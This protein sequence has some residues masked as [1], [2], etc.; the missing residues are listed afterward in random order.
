MRAVRLRTEHM[1][2]PMGIDIRRPCLSWNCEGGIAQTAY[3]IS[4]RE[5]GREIWNSGRG[6]SSR[7]NACFGAELRGRQQVFWRVRLWDEENQPGEWSEEAVFEMGLLEKESFLAKWI[8]PELETAPDKRQPASWLRKRF[9]AEAGKKSRLYITCHG[10]YEAYLNGSRIGDFVLAPGTGSYDKKLA[11]Q[12]YDVTGL[13][14]S[15]ENEL[16]VILGDGWHRG[17]TGVDGDRNLFGSDVS[18]FCQLETDGKAV[19]VSEETWQASQQGPIR[20]NDMQQGECYDARMETEAAEGWHEVKTEDFGISQ[21]VCSNSVPIREWES[22]PGRILTTPNGDRVIDFG[23]NLAG[24]VEFTLTAHAGERIVLYHGEAL[25]ENGNFTNANFQ[26]GKRH[27]EGGIRQRTEYICKEGPNQYK[28][29]FCIFGFR[30]ARIETDNSLEDARFTAHAVYSEMEEAGEFTCP[31]EAVNRLVQNCIWSQKSNFCDIPTDCPTRE[32]AG[33]TGDAGV[34]AETGLFLADCYPVFRKWLGECRLVQKP[35]GRIYNIAP[36]NGKHS[37]F[38][39]I[40]SGSVGWGD[41]C[42]IVPYTLYKRY[43]DIR[44]LEENYEM[45]KNW[46]KYLEAR[47]KKSRLK[48]R[49]KKNPY[50]NYTIDT[51]VDYGEWCEPGVGLEGTVKRSSVGVAT[52]YLS[53]SGR[54]L[55]EIASALGKEEEAKH[56]RE[57]SEMAGKAFRYTATREGRIVS[58]RQCEYVRALAFRLLDEEDSRRAAQDLDALVKKKDY[59]LNTGFLSTPFLCGVLADYGYIDTAYRLLLQ[60]TAPGWLYAVKKGATTIWENWDG[61]REDGTVHASLNHYSYGVIA[62]WLFQGVCGI[63]L[64]DGILT[65]APKPSPLLGAARAVYQSPF[66]RIESSWSY[67][68]DGR[69]A[70]E[71][72][73]PANMCAAVELADGRKARLR[74]G[75]HE[76]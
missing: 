67:D 24:Y 54:L 48:N 65:I 76:L 70:Y 42:I 53:R 72:E 34:F 9:Q 20:E 14:K 45:M 61:I 23:Q 35:D 37:V 73:I 4:A 3:E 11:Y 60:D 32:R 51:G 46:Y 29:K 62:G 8:N 55:G 19:C 30:Y 28:P 59:H 66:G 56:Y 40:L 25:D 17:C 18:L 16:Q 58:E 31:N 10:L 71:F 75:R 74:A 49:L 63:R 57:V 2:N 38:S 33:W 12:T 43:G 26:P 7:M 22:F 6:E 1:K 44:I 27:K 13:L 5:E 50:R 68:A 41:A 64:E 69:V 15:G 36:P 39:G 47:A 21:L 52:A